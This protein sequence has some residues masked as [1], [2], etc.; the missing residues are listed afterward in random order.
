MSAVQRL[1]DFWRGIYESPDPMRRIQELEENYPQELIDEAQTPHFL[2]PEPFY[3]PFEE[4]MSNDL[5]VL[6]MNP[7]AVREVDNYS[8]KINQNVVERYKSWRRSDFLQ[9]CGC[10][11]TKRIPIPRTRSI[12]KESCPLHGIHANGCGWR[13]TRYR[14]AKF[15]V[16]L[17][18]EFLHT[19]EYIPYHSKWYREMDSVRGWM[20]RANATNLSFDAVYEIATERKVKHIVSLGAAWI[21]IL[22]SKGF[23]PEE[24]MQVRN[25]DGNVLGRLLKYQLT[26]DALPI[27]IH[28]YPQAVRLPSNPKVVN[29][30]RRM[31]GL[32]PKVDKPE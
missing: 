6:L 30:M 17:N 19:M 16:G 23:Q 22:S 13:R 4:D 28:L 15:D 27:V 32:P 3:G 20:N 31:L 1:V 29:E 24:D 2:Y 7:G 5:L 9:E 12:C 18:F 8:S 21:D 14:E 11:D 25:S 10:L 26:A